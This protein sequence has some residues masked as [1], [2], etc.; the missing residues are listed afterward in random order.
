MD[1][2]F[3]N[4]VCWSCLRV[5]HLHYDCFNLSDCA[6]DGCRFQHHPTLHERKND[7]ARE[8]R[9]KAQFHS[10]GHTAPCLLQLMQ[11]RTGKH[12]ID[13]MNIMWDSGATVC[14][15]TFKK[16]RE[17]ELVGQK[18]WITIVKVGGERERI[19]SRLYDVPVHDTSG[20]VESFRAY[21]IS[22]ISSPIEAIET[23][24]YAALL[25]VDPSQIQRPEGEV[26]MLIGLEYAGFHPD[27]EK[28]YDHLVLFKNQFGTCL[29]GTHDDLVE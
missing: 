14:L 25:D 23:D 10:P 22:K 3:D 20:M 2:V 21:G 19:E 12:N 4:R 13:N 15:I 28:I 17:L 27:K 1:L 24:K 8:G 16:A 6:I 29:G 7:A 26:D 11:V 18:T 9:V 5:G